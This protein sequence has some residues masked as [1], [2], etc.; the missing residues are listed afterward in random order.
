MNKPRHKVIG[1]NTSDGQLSV[2]HFPDR[3][4]ADHFAKILAGDT[5]KPVEVAV[6]I[7]TWERQAP[8]V[9]T[10]EDQPTGQP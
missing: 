10:P 9:F 8:I 5:N 1:H 4:T 6:V 7:G 2:W 3:E